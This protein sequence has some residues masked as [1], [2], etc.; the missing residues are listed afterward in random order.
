MASIIQFIRRPSDFDDTLTTVLGEAFDAAC[1]DLP[2]KDDLLREIIARRIIQAAQKGER[3]PDRLR[4]IALTGLIADSER[5][6]RSCL[7]LERDMRGSFI[8]VQPR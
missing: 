4:A 6:N 1:R 3:D 5:T 7:D 2:Q 8:K